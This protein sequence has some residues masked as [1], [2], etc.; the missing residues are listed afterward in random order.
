MGFGHSTRTAYELVRGDTYLV[1]IYLYG[2]DIVTPD[3]PASPT[4]VVLDDM[5]LAFDV[6]GYSISGTV[7]TDFTDDG[8]VNGSPITTA[9]GEQLYAYLVSPAS[10][11]GTA[12][13]CRR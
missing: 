5:Y 9:D 7:F 1:R 8:V 6:C 4:S 3:P 13:R 10:T 12:I 11:R 2:S